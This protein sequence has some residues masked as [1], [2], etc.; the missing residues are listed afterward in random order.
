[1]SKSKN[2][3]N[4]MISS[5]NLPYFN[6]VIMDSTFYNILRKIN[7]IINLKSLR[8]VKIISKNKNKK[9]IREFLAKDKKF[10]RFVYKK[11]RSIKIL[12]REYR[13]NIRR[14]G[15]NKT[16]YLTGS[17]RFNNLKFIKF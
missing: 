10:R 7:D 3:T 2:P 8:K 6:K 11:I 17:N 14:A 1:M 5:H 9:L 16:Y 13:S 4:N 15:N 12:K